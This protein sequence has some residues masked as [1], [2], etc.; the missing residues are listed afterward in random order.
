MISFLLSYLWK[1]MILLFLTYGICLWTAAWHRVGLSVCVGL[2]ATEA[3][4]G[5]RGARARGAST[6]EL[7]SFPPLQHMVAHCPRPQ[8]QK[9]CN[10]LACP[11]IFTNC[12]THWEHGKQKTSKGSLLFQST[13]TWQCVCMCVCVCLRWWFQ[14][15]ITRWKHVYHFCKY[16]DQIAAEESQKQQDQ[17]R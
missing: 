1:C 16:F 14:H 9:W 12:P 15:P 7:H 4:V 17:S 6:N 13:Q 3:P 2:S 11:V 8:R 5:S 10:L